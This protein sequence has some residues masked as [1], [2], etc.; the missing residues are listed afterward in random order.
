MPYQMRIGVRRIRAN[1]ATAGVEGHLLAG[2]PEARVGISSV[3]DIKVNP[4][5]SHL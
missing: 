2:A 4:S 1:A 3:P 5:E